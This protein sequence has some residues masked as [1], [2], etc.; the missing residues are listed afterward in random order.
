MG[1]LRAEVCYIAGDRRDC[2]CQP[3]DSSAVKHVIQDRAPSEKQQ[4]VRSHPQASCHGQQLCQLFCTLR[5]RLL[6]LPCPM[7]VQACCVCLTMLFRRSITLNI[8]IGVQD[9]PPA[10]KARARGI[11]GCCIPIFGRRACE[12]A[13]AGEYEARLQVDSTIAPARS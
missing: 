6:M 12:P 7:L 11:L 1:D 4:M 8:T 3:Q 10:S 5:T 9:A 2:L 13:T